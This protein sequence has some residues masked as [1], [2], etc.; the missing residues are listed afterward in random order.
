MKLPRVKLPATSYPPLAAAP[1][2]VAPAPRAAEEPLVEIPGDDLVEETATPSGGV[3]HQPAQARAKPAPAAAP[4]P[5]RAAHR[6]SARPWYEEYF[7]DHHL[8]TLAHVTP[9][10]T[11]REASF[12]L[13]SLAAPEGGDLLDIGCGPGRHA[14]ELAAGGYRLVGV[15]FSLPYLVRAA[16]EA[17]RRGVAVSFVHADMRSL[18]FR[19]QFDG[20]YCLG[21]SFGF[22]D[23][24]GNRRALESAMHALRPGGRLLLEALNRDYVAHDLPGRA[25]F[26]GDGCAVLDEIDF[27]FSTS[28]AEIQRSIVFDDGRQV[29]AELSIRLY[30][31]H[32]LHRLLEQVGFRVIELSGHFAT[33]GRFLG[34]DSRSLLLLVEKPLS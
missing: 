31:L 1:A 2:A 20:A 10:A 18:A 15:D 30:S 3:R 34:P 19:S 22:F 25:W 14:L 6:T 28:R 29:T 4:A 26:E 12:V 7:V 9:H 23:E 32:E 13:E 27:N 24:D 21:G 17:Q 33:R 5:L 8:A 11:R 16:D